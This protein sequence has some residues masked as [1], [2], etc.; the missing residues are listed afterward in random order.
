MQ[1]RGNGLRR[2]EYKMSVLITGANGFLGKNLVGKL[3]EKYIEKSFLTPNSSE[4]NLLNYESV[5]EYLIQNDVDEIIHLA[6]RMSGIGELTKNPL[7]Y[8]EQNLILNY[9]IVHSAIENKVNRFITLGSSCG[10]NNDTPL[11]MKEESFWKLKP[12]NTY[13]ICKLV[14]LEHLQN[15]KDMIWT[16]LVPGNLYGPYDHFGNENAHLIPATILKF[17]KA[18]M[19]QKKYIDVWGDG[20]Q[21]RDFL[22]ID[23]AVDIICSAFENEKYNKKI[24]NISVEKGDT[25]KNIVETIQKIMG[26]ED[27]EIRWDITKP[28]GI[29]KKVLSNNRFMKIEPNYE[30]TSIEDG[31]KQTIEWYNAH[32][33]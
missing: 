8:L 28:T 22:Y 11:P 18:I 19:E 13:G 31:L 30:F 32:K 15:Q 1:L 21:I 4:L 6:A 14:L 23:D 29:S 20:T 5:N 17:E 27:I 3:K 25:V 12:E 7:P 26:L 33:N 9:N 2:D 16:Y 24:L 10:Y